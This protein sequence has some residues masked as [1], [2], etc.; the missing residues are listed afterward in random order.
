M[1]SDCGR[2]K[3]AKAVHESYLMF[4]IIGPACASGATVDQRSL[5][6]KGIRVCRETRVGSITQGK[7]AILLE[8]VRQNGMMW[9]E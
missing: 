1:T 7:E 2:T 5:P 3:A 4:P 9:A 6:T 8:L